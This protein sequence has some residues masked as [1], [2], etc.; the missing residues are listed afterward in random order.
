MASI[1]IQ[2]STNTACASNHG[3]SINIALSTPVETLPLELLQSTFNR[4]TFYDLM[5]YQRIC[6]TW[7]G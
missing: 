3:A 6:K 4:F 2:Q 7:R 1:E 5:R